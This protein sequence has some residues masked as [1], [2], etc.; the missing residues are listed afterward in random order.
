MATGL[1]LA[2]GDGVVRNGKAE[3]AAVSQAAATT[4]G[5]A[6]TATGPLRISMARGWRWMRA[7]G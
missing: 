2:A 3:A 4:G 1:A 5:A 6:T 7:T